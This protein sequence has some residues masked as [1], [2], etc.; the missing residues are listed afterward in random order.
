MLALK[1]LIR[2]SVSVN[3]L[4]L[5]DSQKKKKNKNTTKK[6]LTSLEII[7]ET[8]K[9]DKYHFSQYS[10]MFCFYIRVIF[11]LTHQTYS[12]PST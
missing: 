11:I 7:T 3:N 4:I 2:T 9:H 8:S 1:H 5:S 10:P 6:K 12:V